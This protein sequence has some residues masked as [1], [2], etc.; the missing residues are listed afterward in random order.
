MQ[1]LKSSLYLH[2]LMISVIISIYEL[3]AYFSKH[4][5][6]MKALGL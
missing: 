5:F 1:I 2:D 6:E 3:H 4:Y